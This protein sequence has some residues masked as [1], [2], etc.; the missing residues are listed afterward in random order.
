MATYPWAKR[1]K[2]Y[3]MDPAEFPHLA[4]WRG[5]IEA[6]PA[7]ERAHA[8]IQAWAERDSADRTAATPEESER[9]QGLH[10]RAPSAQAAAAHN[11]QTLQKKG[12]SR[13]G[14]E[15]G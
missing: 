4:D 13:D 5:R 14:E 3:G 8:V 2:R 15:N 9:F 12:A 1:L 10:I 6:R 11:G 7:I